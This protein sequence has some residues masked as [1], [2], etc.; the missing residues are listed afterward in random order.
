MAR[1]AMSQT[2]NQMTSPTTT[3]TM[4]AA[5]GRTTL[6][7]S[8][9][10]LLLCGAVAGPVYVAVTLAQAL[11]R[12]GFVLGQHPFNVLTTGDLGWIQRA[13][14]ALAGVLI[15]AFAVGA[16]RVLRSGRSARWGARLLGLHGV[17][18]IAGGVFA[19]DRVSGFPPGSSPE[20]TWHGIMHVAARGS[21]YAVLIAASLAIAAWFA[22]SGRRAWAWFSGAAIPVVFIAFT[23]ATS[24]DAFTTNLVFLVPLALTWT[25][26]AA[27][28]IYLYQRPERRRPAVPGEGG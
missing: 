12:D 16:R 19:S 4:G 25:W 14:L 7:R 5:G 26:I 2:A 10:S 6:A 15:V 28:A 3:Q 23:I 21:G 1:L 27:L 17:A 9:G 18:Y 20:T 22:T 13:N 8:T 24:V 11:T